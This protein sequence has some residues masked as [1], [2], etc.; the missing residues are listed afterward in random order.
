MAGERP[1]MAC[2]GADAGA[3]YTASRAAGY[4]I[5]AA[6]V[7]RDLTKRCMVCTC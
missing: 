4:T 2:P 3:Y 7:Q 1:E 5:T 6:E